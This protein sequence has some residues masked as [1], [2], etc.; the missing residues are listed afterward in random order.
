M[1]ELRAEKLEKLAEEMPDARGRRRRGRRAAGARLGLDLRRR[2]RPPPGG[3]AKRE[4]PIATAH[5]RHLDPLPRNTGEVVRAFPKV[6]IPELNTGQLLGIIR[7]KFLVDAIGYNKIEGLPIFAEELERRDPGGAVMSENGATNGNGNG[8]ALPTLTK[9]GLPVRPGNPLVPGLRRLRDPRQRPGADAGTRR[10]AG[11]DGL[12]LRD[13]LRRALRLLHGHLRDARHPRPRPGAGDRDRD[14]PRGPL[15]LGRHRRRRLALDRRQP[16]DPRA[17]PQR[18]DQAPALQQ[19]DLRPDQGPVLADQRE[20]QDH[21]VD[22]VRL[23]GPSR[24]TRWRWRSAPRPRSS[25]ARS[26]SRRSTSPRPCAP[27]PS[28]RARPSSRSTRTATSSTTAPSTRSAARAARRTRSASST[29]SRSASAPRTSAAS[30]APPT[31]ASTVADVAEVGEDALVVHDAH[32]DEPEPRDGARAARR[33]A[34]R[35]DPDRRP[36]RRQ[37]PRLRRRPPAGA[38]RG[39][40]RRLA[41]RRR[42][43]AALGRHLDRLLVCGS[44]DPE[45]RPARLRLLFRRVDGHR[46]NPVAPRRQRPA[47]DPA[48]EPGP[49]LARSSVAEDDPADRPEA[50][51]GLESARLRRFDRRTVSLTVARSVRRNRIVAPALFDALDLPPAVTEKARGVTCRAEIEGLALMIRMARDADEVLPTAS[52]ADAVTV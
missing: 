28:T 8:S 25:P 38:E 6:L 19:P 41:G 4:I 5:L 50:L 47:T 18:P 20:G 33:S 45:A 1:T 39:P 30:S 51:T 35:A 2:S 11:E 52:V 14:R 13:R 32:L 43:A 29:A 48:A 10:A 24:S 21:Q 31:A 42:R 16:P 3:S 27:P 7:G 12:H 49:V 36:A 34:Q 9:A 22:P 44:E 26:T 15:G 23:R 17:A 46:D 37:A 40:R